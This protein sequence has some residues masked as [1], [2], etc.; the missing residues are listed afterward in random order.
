[1]GNHRLYSFPYEGAGDEERFRIICTH[2]GDYADE[3]NDDGGEV[4]F[5]EPESFCEYF[6]IEDEGP[7]KAT[8][9]LREEIRELYGHACYACG[10]TEK[11]TV[12]HIMPKSLEGQGIPTNLQLLCDKCNGEKAD[13]VPKRLILGLD[14]LMRPAPWESYEGLIW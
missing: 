5:V 11:L 10:A 1:M 14:F 9:E 3:G 4:L 8:G 7:K 13:K 12:D 2:C 6:G